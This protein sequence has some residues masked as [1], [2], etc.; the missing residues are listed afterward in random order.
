MIFSELDV[1]LLSRIQFALTIMFHYLFPPLTIGLGII[2]AYLE[3]MFVWT[4]DKVYIQA[5]RFWTQIFG[6]NFAIGVA[7]GI[8][9]EF[10][11]GT[12]W[13]MYSRFVG[14]VFGSAL[15]A[16]GIFAFFLESGFL[17]VLVFGYKRVSPAFHFFSACMVALGSIFSSIWITV[18]NSWQQTPAGHRIVQ[19]TR[20]GEPWFVNGEPVMRAEIYDFWAMVFNPSS[21]HRLIHVWLGCF[22]VGACLVLSISAYYVIRNR[23]LEFA[24]KSF[25]GA[26]ILA[27][28]SCLAMFVSGHFQ[29]RMVYAHQPAKMAAFEGHFETGAADMTLVGIP[30]PEKE[31]V[32]FAIGIPG[33]LSFLIH[34][35]FEEPVIG[36]DKF[37]N[38]DRPPVL[39]PFF[40][41]RIMIGVGVGL[42]ALTLLSTFWLFRGTLYQ[43]RWLMWIF[44][45]SIF[46]AI[47]ANEAGWV[48]TEVGRQPWI[49]Q[50]PFELDESGSRIED[51]Q[52]HFVYRESEG[53]RTT[54]AVSRAI[55]SEQ[56]LGSIVMFGF[57]YFLLGALWLFVLNRKIQKGPEDEWDDS[58]PDHKVSDEGHVGL[59]GG[60]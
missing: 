17:A 46:P 54:N 55:K 6:L 22:I 16:E 5:A 29:A 24:R 15:A 33:G 12:N 59:T 14:D 41:Y 13:A 8:V 30:D 44:V 52:G 25:S 19:M 58:D 18:A 35:D 57:G 39:I 36:L 10:E 21:I 37:R 49:V 28:G 50:A 4:K 1:V 60:R 43:R 26:L 47:A 27:L 34:D 38:Q 40:C 42:C 9:M 32:D 7:S 53:L 51:E 56:V 20:D 31:T 3:G 11:F 23:H 2:I 48:A 45:I